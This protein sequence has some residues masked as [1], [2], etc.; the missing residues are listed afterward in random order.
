M[1]HEYNSN[2]KWKRNMTPPRRDYSPIIKTNGN[3]LPTDLHHSILKRKYTPNSKPLHIGISY[4]DSIKFTYISLDDLNFGSFFRASQHLHKNLKD[5][6]ETKVYWYDAYGDKRLVRN[7]Y[8]MLDTIHLMKSY[9]RIIYVFTIEIIKLPPPQRSTYVPSNTCENP[10]EQSTRQ[11]PY[12]Y[13]WLSCPIKVSKLLDYNVQEINK[14]CDTHDNGNFGKQVL[15][16]ARNDF[17]KECH[18]ICENH[19]HMIKRREIS[20]A[21]ILS[22]VC[23]ILIWLT[24]LTLD[25]SEIQ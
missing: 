5:I 3:I 22:I 25:P 1:R 9:N 12:G 6:R 21:M 20:Q 24:Y 8:D 23:I 15:N 7:T 11:V 16:K 13:K 18:L 17:R 14:F 10:N 19:I 2:S 4:M